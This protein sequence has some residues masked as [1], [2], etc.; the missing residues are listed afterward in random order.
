MQKNKI[1]QC[2]HCIF[3]FRIFFLVVSI[4][5]LNFSFCSFIVFWHCCL[6]NSLN[7]KR[8]I[9]NFLTKVIDLLFFQTV[10]VYFSRDIHLWAYFGFLELS[11]SNIIGQVGFPI[12]SVFWWSHCPS[13]EVRGWGVGITGWEQLDRTTGLVPCQSESVGWTL[14]LPGFSGQVF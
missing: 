14:Q 13:S 4:S 12:R 8:I 3:S 7:L 5:L 10:H 1:F 11:A 2:S 6:C 9:L